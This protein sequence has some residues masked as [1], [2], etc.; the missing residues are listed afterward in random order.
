[1]SRRM[2]DWE[3]RQKAGLGLEAWTKW[4]QR[5][6]A[7]ALKAEGFTSDDYKVN[8]RREVG[9]FSVVVS[10]IRDGFLI[11]WTNLDGH[12]NARDTIRLPRELEVPY[13]LDIV[14]GLV[15]VCSNRSESDDQ[16]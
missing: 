10:H 7:R 3:M 8:F 14:R 6:L 12:E 5:D 16:P 13:V 2:S 4:V 1:M 9:A 11:T 15:W